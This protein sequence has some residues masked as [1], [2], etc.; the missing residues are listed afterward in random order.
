MKA[1]D[2][3]RTLAR[4]RNIISPLE[5]MRGKEVFRE[6]IPGL[7]GEEFNPGRWN[8]G[9]VVLNSQKA[10]VLLVTISKR[11]K[12]A[13]HRY[14]DYWVDETT[15]HW[16]SQRQ[17]TPR[18]KRGQELVQHREKGIAIHLFVREDKLAGGKGAPFRYFGPVEYFG[19]SGEA[20]M[21]ITLKLMSH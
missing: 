9:H 12:H 18:D 7:F 1:T 17:T 3:H 19:H 20:P 8:V 16:S 10:H 21:A 6:E 2:E 11:G 15:F 14:L 5:M 13:D 4:L